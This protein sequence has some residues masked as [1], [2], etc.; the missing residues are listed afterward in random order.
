MGCVLNSIS[1]NIV[2]YKKLKINVS[3]EAKIVVS[4][5]KKSKQSDVNLSSEGVPPK[6]ESNAQIIRPSQDLNAQNCKYELSSPFNIL[7]WY[8]TLYTAY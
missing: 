1:K 2:K 3:K 6:S 4:N 7:K 8:K 5:T